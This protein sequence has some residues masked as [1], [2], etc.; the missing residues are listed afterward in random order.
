MYST[1]ANH[2]LQPFDWTNIAQ[3]LGLDDEQAEAYQQRGEKI[4]RQAMKYGL[5]AT[6]GAMQMAVD[7]ADQYSLD[8]LLKA[9]AKAVDVPKWAYVKGILKR[10]KAR[11]SIDDL[12]DR[13]IAEEQNKW[14][15]PGADR[16]AM[17]EW[18]G[19]G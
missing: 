5:K 4:R 18:G 14:W 3:E 11:G 8:W 10:A 16:S 9:I 15:N 19:I 7:L 1:N 12:P 6:E 17:D 2:D 13:E